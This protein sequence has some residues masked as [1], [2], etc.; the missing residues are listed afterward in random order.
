MRDKGTGTVYRI[1]VRGELSDRYAAA[2]EGMQM[3]TK[4]GRTILSG[5]V[6]DQPHLH[7]ILERIGD[8]GLKLESVQDLSEDVHPSVEERDREL[9]SHENRQLGFL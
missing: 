8:L 5:E 9:Q 2:F 4:E 1:G 7:G 6:V 3:E